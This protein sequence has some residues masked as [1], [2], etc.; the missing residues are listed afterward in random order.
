MNQ[1]RRRY[2]QTISTFINMKML[3]IMSLS[4][5]GLTVG[6][7]QTNQACTEESVLQEPGRFLDAHVGGAMGGS[8]QAWTAAELAN[9]RKI[10]TAFEAAIKP[11]LDFTGGQAKASFGLNSK[12]HYNQQQVSSCTYNLGFHKFVCHV[13]TH[14]LAIVTEYINVLRVTANPDFARAFSF[15]YS[16]PAFRNPENTQ[17]H[18]APII[19]IYNYYAFADVAIVA[20]INNGKD[21]LDVSDENIAANVMLVENRPGK[22][23]GFVLG[24]SFEQAGGTNDIYRHRYITHTDIPFLIPASR[25]Q[26]LQDLLEFYE[27]EKSYLLSGNPG[28]KAEIEAVNEKKKAYVQQLL[29][30]K[31]AKWLAA[32]AAVAKENKTFTTYDNINKRSK[33]ATW[34]HFYFTEFYTGNEGLNLY[35]INPDYLKK[36]PPT[37]AQPAII[38]IMYRFRAKDAFGNKLNEAVINK[39]DM[40][41]FGK[42]LQ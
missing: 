2:Y 31:D 18:L 41:A 39:L 12:R 21:F 29:D 22:G 10:M 4:L 35:C 7:Q 40:E 15:D 37:G 17:D 33:D 6:A 14:K 32:P 36:Y 3:M 11:G 28:E 30:N 13:Q 20:A 25:K 9:A 23:Y 16:A 38:K 8:K 1:Q 42:L 24:N 5:S 26:F 27:R 34:G 19:N